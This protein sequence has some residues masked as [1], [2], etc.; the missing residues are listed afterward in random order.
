MEEELLQVDEL[1]SQF[2]DVQVQRAVMIFPTCQ[3][4]KSPVQFSTEIP[5]LSD[6][7]FDP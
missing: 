7:E 5:L 4:V 2:K 1:S 6:D 3:K